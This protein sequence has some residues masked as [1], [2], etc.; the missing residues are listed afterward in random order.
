MNARFQLKLKHF[1]TSRDSAILDEMIRKVLLDQITAYAGFVV[2]DFQRSATGFDLAMESSLS[3]FI[4]LCDVS[5]MTKASPI[6]P[7]RPDVSCLV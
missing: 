6:A 4:Q 1:T 3:E 7:C 5:V 2:L